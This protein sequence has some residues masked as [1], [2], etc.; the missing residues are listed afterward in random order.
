MGEE[1]PAPAG[2]IETVS[3]PA[4]FG[5]EE[6]GQGPEERLALEG[7]TIREHTARGVLVNAAFNV[8]VT[9]L[10]LIQRVVV[11]AFLTASE[12]GLWGLLVTTMITLLWLKQVGLNEKFIQQEEEDQEL[13][14]QKAFTL[15]LGYTLCFY[16]LVLAALP[17]YALLYGREEILVPGLLLSLAFPLSIF[18]TPVWIAYREMR[19]VRQRA[20]EAV[21]PVV[22]TVVAIT[23]AASGAGYWSFVI[24]A[25]AGS[26]AAAI[27]AVVTC[28]YRIRIRFDR[29][30]AREYF[31][32]SWPLF[33][34]SASSLLVVQGAVIVG[35]FTV[36]LA[37]LGA[38]ALATT[39]VT[40][41][42]AVDDI[43]RRTMYPAVCAV[44]TQKELMREAF[45]KSNSLALMWGVPFGVALA[46]FAPDLVQFV[47]GEK[48]R[49]A[50]G[51][52]QALGLMLALRQ[53][54]FN[55]S[56][57][58]NA[59]GDTRPLAV[60]AV[61]TLLTFAAITV[62]LMFSLGL[63]GYAIGMTATV[64]AEII[65]R[66]YFLARL[67]GT[68]RILNHVI[69]AALP[70]VPA[71]AAVLCVRFAIGG[72]RT[73]ELALAELALYVVVAAGA[74]YMI[75]RALVLEALGYLRGTRQAA[76]SG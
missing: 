49:V 1:S 54:A 10:G 57:F 53:V 74:T 42:D 67:F 70:V 4:P 39:F 24:G 20:L 11:A 50:Q 59:V 16:V 60:H 2:A 25:V 56:I 30:T 51:L 47:L 76:A 3:E 64:V 13:A 38:L 27:A 34:V 55:W 45:T 9:G 21:L 36:G 19:F 43:L 73:I 41:V 40:Y 18:T 68:R 58:I 46:L 5:I 37:G 71:V 48:W 14:F 52:I 72:E 65:V 6:V 33:V 31:G 12:F 62:P 28:P 23:L 44:R 8:G 69:P 22:M 75:G 63:T 26:V 66:T 61:V 32:F 7:R 29:A 17:L 35:N 15:E